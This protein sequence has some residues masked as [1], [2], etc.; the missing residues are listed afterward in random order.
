MVG[1]WQRTD[2]QLNYKDKEGEKLI[3]QLL[4]EGAI[5]HHSELPI[6]G[7]LFGIIAFVSFL[8]LGL[9]TMSYRD[10]ANRHSHKTAGTK[11]SH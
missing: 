3:S 8:A 1:S 7:I 10:V 4:A 5:V 6:P 11:A 2:S 9:V